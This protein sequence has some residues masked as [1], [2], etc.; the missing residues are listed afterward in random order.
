MDFIGF[1]FGVLRVV[2]GFLLVLFLP[3]FCLSLLYYPRATDLNFLE[4]L[5]Y[6]AVLSIGSVMVLV[7]FMEF[8]LGVNTTPRN[9]ALFI[10]VL[11]FFCLLVWW[12]EWGYLKSRLKTHLDLLF[13]GEYH[14][15]RNFFLRGRDSVRD[16]FLRTT[17]SEIVYHTIRKDGENHRDHSYLI[18]VGDEIDIRQIRGI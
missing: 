5:V 14:T 1:I 12:V 9:I 6:S 2:F 7:L 4:R 3:G 13:S 15:L 16:R 8:I 18:D 10:C 17:R 11:S